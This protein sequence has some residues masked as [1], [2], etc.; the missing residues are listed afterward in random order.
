MSLRTE[1]NGAACCGCIGRTKRFVLS[2]VI[3]PAK[4]FLHGTWFGAVRPAC[5]A[6]S[7]ASMRIDLVTDSPPGTPVASA[8]FAAEPRH[9]DN[10]GAALCSQRRIVAPG[11]FDLALASLASQPFD[12][13]DVTLQ[14]Y[15]CGDTENAIT[16]GDLVLTGL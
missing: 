1:A 5:D 3:D 13:I 14:G 4:A 2:R 16:L 10:C 8:T 11:P 12:E 15:G 6:Y 7:L 9:F